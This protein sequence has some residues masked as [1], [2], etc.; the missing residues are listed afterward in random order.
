MNMAEPGDIETLNLVVENR[1]DQNASEYI[2]LGVVEE[3][4]RETGRVS[5]QMVQFRQKDYECVYCQSFLTVEELDEM[6]DA[7]LVAKE[8]V[9]SILAD[10]LSE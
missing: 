8:R 10:S 5:F 1:L 2:R 3:D 9:L 4:V 7:I 6:V